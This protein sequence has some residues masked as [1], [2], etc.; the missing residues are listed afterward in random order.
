MKNNTLAAIAVS[1]LVSGIG[2]TGHPAMA[3][4][5]VDSSST[6]SAFP[7]TPQNHWAYEA[8]QDLANKG[9]VK[10][11]PNGTFIG[12]RSLSRYE[13][14]TVI[15]RMLQT[16]EDI[17]AAP[18]PAAAAPQVTEDDLNKI[19]VLVDTFQTQLNAIQDD[20]KK[21]DDDIEALRQDVLD[22]KALVKKAQDTA[23]HS[24][25]T[26]L[27]RKFSITG[28]V[29]ARL[30]TTTTNNHNSFPQG[31]SSDGAGGAGPFNGNYD[32]LSAP[33]QAQVR[34]ARIIMNGAP[35][36]NTT[37]KIQ[38]DVAG[39]VKAGPGVTANSQISVLEAW[40][41]YAFGDGSSKYPAIAL[42]EFAN[43]FGWI[44]PASPAAWL[45]PERPL[46]FS[47][48]TNVGLFDQQ[49]YD[50]G[51]RLVYAPGNIR[52]VYAA[53]NGAGRQSENTTGH[54]D[55]VFHASYTS[56]DKQFNLGASYYDGLIDR[57]S[58]GAT[59]TAFPEPKKQLVD[60]DAEIN[61]ND[62]AFLQGE[63]V[64]GLYEK[65][66]Y[67]DQNLMTTANPLGADTLQVDNYVKG[68]HVNG[69]YVWGGYTFRKTSNHALTFGVDYDVF[70]RSMSAQNNSQ[71]SL[72][73]GQ[74]F[75]SS[76]SAFDD[77][78]YGGG[79]MYNLDKSTRL[80]F[81]YEDPTEV[82][83]APGTP[84]PPKIGLYTAEMLV[85]F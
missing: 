4:T 9:L 56:T 25:G 29:E 2:V 81:W 48:A 83:H 47:E 13:F 68:N 42:G 61:L 50:K 15:D 80:R 10:G 54:L 43:P 30:T 27:N 58:P 24:Y 45:T 35:T 16:L 72:Q 59:V 65:R 75:Y 60:V 84:E 23:D 66:A 19:Q 57:P 70:Q 63:W 34:R 22:T 55:S 7:D 77:V 12:N 51:L 39:P 67:Y 52:L 71:N 20:V 41:Q 21:S 37:Y 8:V 53:V 14:A 28:L 79:V 62:G 6:S 31:Y 78:N 76:G 40:G 44:L 3:Q 1:L 38:L 36:N 17:K 11:Y 74:P 32:Q 85:R 26:S 18:S 33:T 5:A 82:A 49:D 46:A 73:S 64:N 69:Y